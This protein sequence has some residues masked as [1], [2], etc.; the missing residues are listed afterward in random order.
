MGDDYDS[1]SAPWLSAFEEDEEEEEAGPSIES[2]ESSTKSAVIMLVDVNS[3]MFQTTEEKTSPLSTVLRVLG[4]IV[5]DV[6]ITSKNDLIGLVFFNSKKSQNNLAVEH[7]HVY[8]EPAEPDAQFIK[9]IQNLEEKKLFDANVGSTKDN[10][11]DFSKALWICSSLFSA[12]KNQK[13]FKRV[14][15]FTNQNDPTDGSAAHH[16]NVKQRQQDM[17][18]LGIA[19][20]LFPLNPEFDPRAFWMNVI[21]IPEDESIDNL[22]TT[23]SSNLESLEYRVRKREYKKRALGSVELKIAPNLAIA[24]KL[25]CMFK[26]Q[27]PDGAKLLD[28]ETNQPLTCITRWLCV[29]TASILEDHQINKYLTYGGEKVF[30]EKAEVDTIKEVGEPGITL[31]GF[32]SITKLKQY[33]NV[34]NPYFIYPDESSIKGSTVAFHALLMELSKMNKFAVARLIYRKR[35]LMK[36]VALVPQLEQVDSDGVQRVPPGFNMIFL[37]FADDIRNLRFDPQPIAN[38]ETIVKA[39]A[40]VDKLKINFDINTFENP[41]LQK[42]Y[43]V[44]QA[45][46]LDEPVPD[47]VED[48]VQPDEKAFAKYAPLFD[49]FHEAVAEVVSSHGGE[50]KSSSSSSRKRKAP[51]PRTSKA[52]TKKKAASKK[53]KSK[54]EADDDDDDDDNVIV[55][56]NDDKEESSTDWSQYNTEAKLK[57]L[58]V[59][60]LKECCRHYKLPVSGKKDDL[61]QR[62]IKKMSA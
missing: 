5:K 20:E 48:T 1:E 61:I 60:V 27:K 16:N 47:E 55:N 50:E 13:L 18:E 45:I 9:D 8:R 57:K 49:A 38:P 29:S 22:R 44:L 31:M 26:V 43:S 54:K 6:I 10:E 56:D 4:N 21:E 3:S 17:G 59:P 30:F 28:P 34:R 46:A 7:V 40:L 15:I 53:R 33:H 14:F 24:V 62:I 39:K 35:G 52:A 41:G 37:P 36:F 51:A 19:L 25:Y 2:E 23:F 11:C 42:H 32:K 12:I 58:T